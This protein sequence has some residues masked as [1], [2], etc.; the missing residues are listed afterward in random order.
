MV[1]VNSQPGSLGLN[2]PDRAD[3]MLLHEQVAAELR[4]AILAG[5][6]RPGER[7][8]QARDLADELGVNTNT[9]LRA[10]RALR[11]EG[12]VEMGRGRTLR[13]SGRPDQGAIALKLKEL[14]A[15][16]RRHGLGRDDLVAMLERLPR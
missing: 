12:I 4:R 6:A 5:E 15:E 9:V 2:P 10:L 8:P 3:P 1:A 7:L 16:A 13:V 11:D 14:V